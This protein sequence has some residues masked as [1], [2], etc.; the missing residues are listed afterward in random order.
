MIHVS[1]KHGLFLDY[2]MFKEKQRVNKEEINH[3][4]KRLAH[5]NKYKKVKGMTGGVRQDL[6][7][8]YKNPSH[9]DYDQRLNQLEKQLRELDGVSKTL[10]DIRKSN[11]SIYKSTFRNVDEDSLTRSDLSHFNRQKELLDNIYK[12]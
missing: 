6:Q 9:P 7:E 5:T 8:L 2:E 1:G 10:S 3:L 11:P 4:K 12:K